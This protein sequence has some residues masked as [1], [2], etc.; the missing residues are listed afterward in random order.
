MNKQ[1]KELMLECYHPYG[2][3][4]YEKFAKLIVEHC[5]QTLMNNGY[6]DASEILKILD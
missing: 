4:D 5:Q 6:D 2:N 3:F 1:I